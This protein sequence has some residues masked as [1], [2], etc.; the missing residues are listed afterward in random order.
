MTTDEFQAWRARLNLTYD[1]AAVR[2]GIHRAT[3]ARYLSGELPIPLTVQL[4][5]K[6]VE[7]QLIASS[8]GM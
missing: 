6:E 3:V 5:C 8:H 1:E 4:A 2:L 7:R